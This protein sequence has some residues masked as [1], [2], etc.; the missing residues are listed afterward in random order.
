MFNCTGCCD[1][2]TFCERKKMK[3][4][5]EP[6]IKT[7]LKEKLDEIERSGAWLGRQVGRSTS[8]IAPYVTGEIIPSYKVQ[9]MIAAVLETTVDELWPAE[10]IVYES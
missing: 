10:V 4:R 6:I 9:V 8:Q 5:M 3:K 2:S 1:N 7:K